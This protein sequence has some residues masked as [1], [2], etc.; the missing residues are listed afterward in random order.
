M[1]NQNTAQFNYKR[2][3]THTDYNKPEEGVKHKWLKGVMSKQI[4]N[5]EKCEYNKAMFEDEPSSC[6]NNKYYHFIP[7]SDFTAKLMAQL[8]SS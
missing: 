1:V 2:T 8:F 6:P 7:L 3:V 4:T 5:P